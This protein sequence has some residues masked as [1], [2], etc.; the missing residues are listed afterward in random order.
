MGL[1]RPRERT[2]VGCAGYSS[3]DGWGTLWPG[4]PQRKCSLPGKWGAS[5]EWCAKVGPPPPPHTSS[6]LWGHWE[7]LAPEWACPSLWQVPASLCSYSHFHHTQAGSGYPYPVWVCLRQPQLSF[8]F[9]WLATD[10]WGGAHAETEPK[11]KPRP[12]GG[13]TKGEEQKSL[14]AAA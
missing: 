8:P 1:S 5:V 10:T 12:R 13:G 7:G 3:G 2:A 9:T 4:M 6:Y 14:P 11:P